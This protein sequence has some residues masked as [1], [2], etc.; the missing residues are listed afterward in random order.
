VAAPCEVI[1]PFS[2]AF[3]ASISEVFAVISPTRL[4]RIEGFRGPP[5]LVAV[6]SMEYQ[7]KQPAPIDAP[8]LLYP[9]NEGSKL[10]MADIPRYTDI[11][12]TIQISEV[13]I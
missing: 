9:N 7:R 13:R 12:P 11:Q 6:I 3:T 1:G 5:N 8:K 2:P 4:P 10:D